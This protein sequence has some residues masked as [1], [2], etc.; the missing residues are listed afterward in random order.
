MIR[1]LEESAA[2]MAG[3]FSQV[4]AKDSSDNDVIWVTELWDITTSH[5]ASLSLP[6]VKDVSEVH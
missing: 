5:Q 6:A 1:V 4:L 3:C 2:Y